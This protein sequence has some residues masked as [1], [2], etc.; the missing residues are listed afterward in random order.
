MEKKSYIIPIFGA[1]IGFI[2]GCF[3]TFILVFITLFSGAIHYIPLIIALA[4]VLYIGFVL[5]SFD[6]FTRKKVAKVFWTFA[7]GV[8]GVTAMQPIFHWF[9][10]RIPTVDAEV[11]I[12]QYEPFVKGNQV[13]KLP[14]VASLQLQEPLP[15][16]DGATALYPLY[17]AFVQAVYPEKMYNPYSSEVMVNQTP[18]AYANLLEGKVDMIFAAGPS[19]QQIQRAQAKGMEL[20][21]TPIGKE[22]FVFFVNAKNNINNLTLE[23]IKDIYAGEIT[24]WSQVGGKKDAIRAFQRPQDSGSQTALQRLMG[25]KPIVEAPSENIATGM[26]GIINEVSKY[27]NY[28]NAI[29]YTFRYYSNEMV[30]SKEIKLLEID[31]VAPTKE[32]IRANTYPITSDFY[33]VTTG[34]ENTHVQA[35]I[36]WILSE[37]G[38]RLV[39]QAGYVP[40][41]EY[42]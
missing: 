21:L 15:K 30:R 14:Q 28:K 24:N 39:E 31:G 8:L 40:V 7:L 26:G 42:E 5:H 2:G 9:D 25:D 4:A 32:T 41:T 34:D 12:Y 17:A 20:K 35:F 11:N 10:N 18:D 3:F 1:I 36:D 27:K 16:I 29:G 38:Q 23:Q 22:A 13:E 37:E 19:E 6:F 33:I